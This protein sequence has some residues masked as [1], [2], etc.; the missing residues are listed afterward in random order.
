MFPWEFTL[1]KGVSSE[2]RRGG[3]PDISV[4]PALPRMGERL[5]GAGGSTP[6]ALQLL[7]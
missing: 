4:F 2:D 6:P 1:G 7:L 3:F 5:L